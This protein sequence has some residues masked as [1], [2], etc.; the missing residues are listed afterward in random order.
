MKKTLLVLSFLIFVSF[1]VAPTMGALVEVTVETNRP[2]YEFSE[3]PIVSV[4]AYNPNDYEVTLEYPT[5]YQADHII[6]GTYVW[7]QGMV[8]AQVVTSVAIEPFGSWT[9]IQSRYSGEVLGLGWHSVVG[10]TYGITSAPVSFE[11]VPEPAT[12]LLLGLG[13]LALLR[14]RKTT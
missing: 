8:F 2:T 4:I 11:V 13:G 5:A 3:I 1:Q 10:T 6:D 12:V 14:R 7:S 9:W